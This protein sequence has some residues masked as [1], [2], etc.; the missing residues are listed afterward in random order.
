MAALGRCGLPLRPPPRAPHGDPPERTASLH[1]GV[2]VDS[3]AASAEPVPAAAAGF[4]AYP[5]AR[6]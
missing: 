1:E 3:V 4:E 5:R 2:T 6:L